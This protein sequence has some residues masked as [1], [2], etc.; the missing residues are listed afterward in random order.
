MNAASRVNKPEA[1]KKPQLNSI[2]PAV[3][4]IGLVTSPRS[5]DGKPENFLSAVTGEHES[6]D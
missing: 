6:N 2:H 5:L 4:P 3:I 1:T